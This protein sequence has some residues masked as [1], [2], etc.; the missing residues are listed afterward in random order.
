MLL[1]NCFHV[2]NKHKRKEL[3]E[4]FA[5][6]NGEEYRGTAIQGYIDEAKPFTGAQVFPIDTTN[7]LVT[8]L[9]GNLQ[10]EYEANKVEPLI[11]SNSIDENPSHLLPV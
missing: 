8:D 9:Q 1:K 2:K 4:I 11:I 6:M 10:I 7:N 3:L 5:D